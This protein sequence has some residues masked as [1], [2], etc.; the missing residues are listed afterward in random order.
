MKGWLAS[1]ALPSWR[2]IEGRSWRHVRLANLAQVAEQR[3]LP[4]NRVAL[5]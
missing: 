1:S 2:V 3:G 4:V 5:V